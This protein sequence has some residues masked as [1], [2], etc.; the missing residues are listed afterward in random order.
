MNHQN[1]IH[2]KI[3]KSIIDA[4]SRKK[5]HSLGFYGDHLQCMNERFLHHHFSTYL[6]KSENIEIFNSRINNDELT[7]FPEYPTYKVDVTPDTKAFYYKNNPD[8]HLPTYRWYDKS[9]ITEEAM[10]HSVGHIDFAIGT[11]VA[12]YF[13]PRI[14][15]EF[16]LGK[17]S[18]KDLIFDYLKLIDPRM[19]YKKCISASINIKN[20]ENS[21]RSK[22]I[23]LFRSRGTTPHTIQLLRDS[24]EIC[25]IDKAAPQGRCCTFLHFEWSLTE[26]TGWIFEYEFQ[27]EELGKFLDAV[28]NKDNWKQL[29]L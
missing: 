5:A 26:S 24:L 13:E 1:E 25:G 15:I 20:P 29:N 28:N 7:L 3:I 17:L 2:K 27:Q 4:F 11:M 14:A 19:S 21:N 8:E 16:K 6:S 18:K 12:K 10:K 22:D 9:E 23:P